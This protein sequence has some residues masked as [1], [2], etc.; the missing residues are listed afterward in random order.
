MN[1]SDIS[2]TGKAF[3]LVSLIFFIVYILLMSFSNLPESWN[4]TGFVIMGF[5]GGGIFFGSIF[6]IGLILWL[7]AKSSKGNKK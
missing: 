6:L 5:F 7:V 3:M 2:K 1:Q 4:R